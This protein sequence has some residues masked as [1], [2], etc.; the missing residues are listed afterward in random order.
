VNERLPQPGAP[1][2]ARARRRA[3]VVALLPARIERALRRRERYKYVQPRVEPEGAGWKIV[4][5]N[6]SR[7]VDAAGG[8]IDIAWF[9]QDEDRSW[10]LHARDHGHGAWLLMASGLTLDAAIARVC[11]DPRREYWK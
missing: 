7:N 6:C 1:S 5:P 4:S 9:V 2:A 10:R 3:A 8:Q 11:A